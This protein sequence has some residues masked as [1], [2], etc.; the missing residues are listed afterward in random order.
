[1]TEWEKEIHETGEQV[2]K[3]L[4][5]FIENTEFNT[6]EYQAVNDYLHLQM[7]E[8]SLQTEQQNALSREKN[9]QNKMYWESQARISEQETAILKAQIDQS[10]SRI[11]GYDKAFTYIGAGFEH[12]LSDAANRDAK[13]LFSDND[14]QQALYVSDLYARILDTAHTV[15]T[16]K[17]D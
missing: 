13:R 6:P 10:Q 1:M 11:K 8:Q 3:R 14:E 5:D 12:D 2:A 7:L 17:R 4:I 16:A 9:P 15:L